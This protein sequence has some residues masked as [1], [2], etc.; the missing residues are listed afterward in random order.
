MEQVGLDIGDISEL[1]L[2]S[3]QVFFRL[4]VRSVALISAI[5][6]PKVHLTYDSKSDIFFTDFFVIGQSNA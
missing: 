6:R 4:H 3:I 1:K 5:F 2:L